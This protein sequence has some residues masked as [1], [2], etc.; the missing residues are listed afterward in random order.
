MDHAQHRCP[1]GSRTLWNAAFG[2]HY[3]SQHGARTESEHVFIQA[4]LAHAAERFAA[5]LHI[6]ELGFG[7]GLNA[8]L[9]ANWGYSLGRQIVYHG[10]EPYPVPWA[11]VADWPWPDSLHPL[12]KRL[13][14]GLG[15]CQ[16]GA[17]VRITPDETAYDQGAQT[18]NPT[19]TEHHFVLHKKP[20]HAGTLDAAA[21]GSASPVT[22]PA[23]HVVFH[24]AFS[25]DNDPGSWRP[26]V[27]DHL[28]QHLVPGGVWVSYCAKG[29]VRRRLQDCGFAVQRLPGPPFKREIL[30]AVK[31]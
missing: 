17:S 10:Y 23:F 25:P 15:A 22:A 4:G 16:N 31:P 8:L 2:E 20:L 5:P 19:A 24:D 29:V 9:A 26:E 30:R 12:A 6:L 7:T 13:H 14:L 28:F 18:G 11:A 3:H 21:E 27:L 1:D